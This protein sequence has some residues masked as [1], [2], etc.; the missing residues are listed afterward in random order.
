MAAI[1]TCDQTSGEHYPIYQSIEVAQPYS[2]DLY[3]RLVPGDRI[4]VK[5]TWDAMSNSD[6][7]TVKVGNSSNQAAADATSV[8]SPVHVVTTATDNLP[9]LITTTSALALPNVQVTIMCSS[10]PVTGAV[11]TIQNSIVRDASMRS[12]ELITGLVNSSIDAAYAG[13]ADAANSFMGYAGTVMMAAPVEAGSSTS[14]WAGLRYG[15]TFG[16]SDQ[17]TGGQVAG[18]AGINFQLDDAWVVGAFGGVENSGY[19]LSALNQTMGGQGVSLGVTGAYRFGDWRLELLGY[20]SALEYKLDNAGTTATF[21]AMRYVIDGKIV[22]TLPVSATVDFAPEMGLAVVNEHQNAY[23]DSAATSYAAQQILAARATA[24]GKF[25][26]YPLSGGFVFSTGAY[27]D[28][29]T[30]ENQSNSGLT[31]RVELG[32]TI[33]LTDSAKLGVKGGLNSI[34]GK[35]LGASVDA[36]IKAAF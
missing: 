29:W 28:Y 33:D 25:V 2:D 23:T 13:N 11:E 9:F 34:G 32:T 35:Q 4:S 16:T 27:A 8:T 7:V 19:A 1:W 30:T 24:G 21:G 31:G 17:W 3:V 15:V 10:G 26:F 6:T 22:G 12:T 14:M 20:G 36:G 5:L 18:G